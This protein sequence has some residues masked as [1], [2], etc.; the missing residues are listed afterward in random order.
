MD[1]GVPQ[2]QGQTLTFDRAS[3]ATNRFTMADALQS[4][5]RMREEFNGVRSEMEIRLRE[6][7]LEGLDR[8]EVKIDQ[9]RTFHMETR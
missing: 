9:L 7:W 3:Q 6:E 5:I 8:I 4:E 2:L 1:T